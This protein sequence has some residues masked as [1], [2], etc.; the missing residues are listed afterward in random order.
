MREDRSREEM[1]KK[2]IIKETI[3]KR[4]CFL[5][6]TLRLLYRQKL[7]SAAVFSCILFSG[8]Q[9][10]VFCGLGCYFWKQVHGEKEG[11]VSYGYG[12]VILM[13]LAVVLLVLVFSCA[14]AL[15]RNL[16]SMAFAQRWK[17]MER[18]LI[19]GATGKE[20]LLL[21]AA[22]TGLLTAVA[23][24]AGCVA[25]TFMESLAGLRLEMPFWMMAG[26]W[27][28]I[29]VLSFGCG[30]LPVWRAVRK[31]LQ[32]SG[33]GAPPVAMKIQT[34][35]IRRTDKFSFAVFMA[36]KYA[37]SDRR[38][39][40]RIT[41]TILAAVL[42]YVP[43]ADLIRQNL[44]ADRAGLTEKYGISY[45]CIPQEREQLQKGI[46]ECRN[47]RAAITAASVGYVCVRGTAS[48]ASE[49]LSSDLTGMLQKAG[50]TREQVFQADS[51]IYFLDD[52]CYERYLKGSVF[53]KRELPADIQAAPVLVNRYKNR[54]RYQAHASQL[55]QET[56][57]LKEC[58]AQSGGKVLE[59]SEV[60]IFFGILQ[61]ESYERKW[62][63]PAVCCEEFPEGIHSENVT[64]ILPLSQLDAFCPDPE[65]EGQ[66]MYIRALFADTEETMYVKLRQEL[67]TDA[68]GVLSDDRKEYQIW[69]DSLWEIH[70]ALLAVCGNLFFMAM[71][72][73][74]SMVLF[75]CM[76]RRHGLAVL[77]SV[78]Q[79]RRNLA[80]IL[81][82]ESLRGFLWA[83]LSAVPVCCGLC[84]IIY[85]IY[86]NVWQVDFSLP[87]GQF[88]QIAGVL[89]ITTAAAVTVSWNRM[90]RQDFL[91]ELRNQ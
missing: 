2:N 35:K 63:E 32:I 90:S 88:V 15:V 49:L 41:Y 46:T 73:V 8:I 7:R 50:W 30:V 58:G 34:G 75:H 86:R 69:Y 67:G 52:D 61:D 62:T 48:V 40:R 72:H 84:Y 33:A 80:A 53:S 77:W 47:L 4:H 31:P 70:L 71:I 27:G 29:T 56:A 66:G 44:E 87:L 60:K 5:W 64:L 24:L 82:L 20:M 3:R 21:A 51:D 55:F 11:T 19:L 26:I 65:R 10:Q 76:Q 83:M 59:L 42:L 36:G 54:T 23:G 6:L 25:L 38:R 17:S 18:F 57:L 22:D 14:A 45:T 1:G 9:L 13:L 91:K 79:T 81:A 85:R 68:A 16:F 39:Q 28:W 89:A 74:F 37:S 78:G 12:Q 43:A